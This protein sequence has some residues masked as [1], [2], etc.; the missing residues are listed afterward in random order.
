MKQN[1]LISKA[2]MFAG[3][4]IDK[5][6][7]IDSILLFGSVA[8]GDFDKES[9]IDIFVETDEEKEN[10][11]KI[12]NLFNSSMINENFSIKGINNDIVVKAG[13][14][15]EWGSLKDSILADGISLYNK[16]DASPEGLKHEYIFKISLDKLKRR[17]KVELWRQLY[18]YTQKVKSKTY[19]YP[20]IIV[21]KQGKKMANGIFLI[22]AKHKKTFTTLLKENKV[23]YEL[24]EVWSK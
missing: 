22:P 7:K 9:D 17:K 13:R 14:L 1:E 4:L 11:Q 3:F 12:L 19:D 10:I 8:R 2:L 21:N 16:Y 20:G 6:P 24:H 5:V 18:G 23:S 15:E